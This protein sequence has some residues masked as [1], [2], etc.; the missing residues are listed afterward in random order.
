M[1]SYHERKVAYGIATKNSSKTLHAL[2]RPLNV[3][4]AK[5]QSGGTYLKSGQSSAACLLDLN[6]GAAALQTQA[7][8]E[9][10]IIMNIAVSVPGA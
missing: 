6:K 4:M 7:A 10:V 9:R 5:A 8:T 1:F 2:V 3:L